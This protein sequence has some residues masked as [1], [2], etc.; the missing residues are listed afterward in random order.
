MQSAICFRSLLIRVAAGETSTKSACNH[1]WN[2]IGGCAKVPGVWEKREQC[3]FHYI[4][5][6]RIARLSLDHIPE[7]GNLPL[8][9][10]KVGNDFGKFSVR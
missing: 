7:F 1:S 9:N 4:N 5:K 2:A 6:L 8:T 3:F 10:E